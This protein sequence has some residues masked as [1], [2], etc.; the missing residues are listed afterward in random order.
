MRAIHIDSTDDTPKVVLDKEQNHFEFSGKSLPHNPS[1]FY[2]PI[3]DWI[4]EYGADPNKLTEVIFKMDY[5]NTASSKMIL[6]IFEKLEN[7]HN[8]GHEV[9]IMWYHD[10]DDVDM[11][12]AG[13]EY[14]EIV[15][16]PIKL[17]TYDD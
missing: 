6:D 15:D 16:V 3:I 1:K 2:Y 9:V 10:E 4:V 11:E 8:N 13:E 12:E 7:I 17:H 5:F 14:S